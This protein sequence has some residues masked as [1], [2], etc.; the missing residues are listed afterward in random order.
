MGTVIMDTDESWPYEL[1][2]PISSWHK[3]WSDHTISLDHFITN[4]KNLTTAKASVDNF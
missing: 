4:E 1:T 2:K 3:N